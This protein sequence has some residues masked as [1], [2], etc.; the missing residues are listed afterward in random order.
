MQAGQLAGL[1]TGNVLANNGN[2]VIVG[3]F[4]WTPNVNAHG[5]DCLLAIVETTQDPSN[6]VNFTPT[7]TIQEWRLVRHDNNIGQR[8]VQLIP[9]GGGMEA[10]AQA[11]DGA[12]FM[13]GNNFNKA[14]Q[15]EIRFELPRVLESRGWKLGF[16]G[17]DG[18]KFH[19]EAGEKR[20]IVPLSAGSQFTGEDVR[21]E[22]DRDVVVSLY[23]DGIL[24]GG[25]SYRLDPEMCKAPGRVPR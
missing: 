8:N 9:G 16:G 1:P 19:L 4:A 2:E 6:V 14:A 24:L 11:L 7:Q 17:L 21:R 5:H 23:G 20:R 22:A 3:P 10:L 13:A 12:F 18:T 25:M 15:M